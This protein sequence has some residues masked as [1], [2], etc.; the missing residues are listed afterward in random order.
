MADAAAV[1]PTNQIHS[2]SSRKGVRVGRERC[3]GIL[4]LDIHAR[5]PTCA[6]PPVGMPGSTGLCIRED[7]YILFDSG[8]SGPLPTSVVLPFLSDTGFVHGTP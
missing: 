4:W 3:F 5:C 6:G 7:A 1:S 8:F 2:L